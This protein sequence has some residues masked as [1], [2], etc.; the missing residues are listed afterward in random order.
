MPN[1]DERRM[2]GLGRYSN[3]NEFGA[4]LIM[5]MGM[6]FGLVMLSRSIFIKTAAIAAGA[7]LVYAT[8]LTYSR[9]CMALFGIMA[10]TAGALWGK[11]NAVKKVIVLGAVGGLLFTFLSI[12]PGP[13]QERF[14]SILNFNQDESFLGRQRAWEQG[15]HMVRN[16]PLFGVG[17]SQWPEYHGKAPHN[18]FVQA[19]AETG[20]VGI[21]FY[22]MAL[23]YALKVN[24]RVIEIPVNDPRY[25]PRTRILAICLTATLV[26]YMVYAFFGN[27][28][29]TPFMYI[30][31]GLCAGIANLVKVTH[32]KVESDEPDI[33]GKGKK[34]KKL[35]G[36]KR[37]K[38][39]N[40]H[41]IAV[42]PEAESKPRFPQAP[43]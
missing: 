39:L 4:I 42:V 26:G 29:Y 10:M 24:L 1:E 20:F 25:N 8:G 27:Q 33:K 18:S 3:A 13:I 6:V 12:I 5:P 28:A 19:M 35:K 7:F 2:I 38:S 22:V 36:K 30:Y 23:F 32:E 14:M 9:T 37:S 34:K 17:M 15:F 41:E 43:R 40:T 21:A 31:A 11:G 16:S